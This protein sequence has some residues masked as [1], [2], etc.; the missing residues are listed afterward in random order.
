GKHPIPPK[1]FK[2]RKDYLRNLPKISKEEAKFIHKDQEL[3]KA[4]KQISQDEERKKN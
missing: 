1:L 2:K 4:Y 3:E